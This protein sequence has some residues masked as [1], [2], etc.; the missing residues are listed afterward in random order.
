MK[1]KL[2]SDAAKAKRNI[3]SNVAV[4]IK[5]YN[6]DKEKAVAEIYQGPSVADCLTRALREVNKDV[7]RLDKLLI[8][9]RNVF[10]RVFKIL[11]DRDLT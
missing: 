3:R 2:L 1:I 9:N 11:M 4:E 10:H 5:L 6:I 8:K 7:K